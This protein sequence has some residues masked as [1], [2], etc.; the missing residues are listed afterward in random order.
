[1]W[2]PEKACHR[3]SFQQLTVPHFERPYNFACWTTH[4]REEAAELGG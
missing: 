4:D 2:M 3:Q 1:V